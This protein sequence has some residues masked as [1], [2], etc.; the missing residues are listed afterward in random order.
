MIKNLCVS[1][2]NLAVAHTK[3]DGAACPGRPKWKPFAEK[4]NGYAISL[5]YA[6]GSH[7]V[8]RLYRANMLA[9][10][11][12]VRGDSSRIQLSGELGREQN[13]REKKSFFGI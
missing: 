7:I 8:H 3:V 6:T 12:M 11:N 9:H 13:E 2:R 1:F 5:I 10:V 4:L